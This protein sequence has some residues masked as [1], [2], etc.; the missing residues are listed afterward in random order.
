MNQE[1]RRFKTLWVAPA[2][3]MAL[4]KEGLKVRE[5][6]EIIEGLPDDAQLLG[7]MYDVTRNG[8]AMVVS[9]SKFPEVKKG[10]QAPFLPVSIKTGR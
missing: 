7:V 10:E 5:D 3:F 4:F 9:S 1:T 2:Q 6:F 8:I